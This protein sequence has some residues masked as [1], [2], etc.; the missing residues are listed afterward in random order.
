MSAPLL[1]L[2]S[3]SPRRQTLLAQ[4][5]LE[6]ETLRLREAAGRPRDVVEEAQDAA[7]RLRAE[8]S[9]VLEV[10]TAHAE[11]KAAELTADAEAHA[12]RLR[13]V[14][15]AEVESIVEAARHHGR[16]M[17]DEAKAARERV[18]VDLVRRRA[19]LQAQ[20]EELR[21]GR[22]RLLDAYRTVKRTFLE[23][24]EAL[25]QVEARAAAERN[26]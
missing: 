23:A 21:G 20:I 16:E 7:D 12:A 26:T 17:L 1:Y 13:E 14:A 3:K 10:R 22:D 2:A 18:L 4:L 8:A 9:E 11:A 25:T 24:T 15:A 6:F 5:G 19:L